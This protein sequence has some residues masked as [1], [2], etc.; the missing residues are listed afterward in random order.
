[1]KSNVNFSNTFERLYSQKKKKAP[2]HIIEK[3]EKAIST[4]IE[5]DNPESCGVKKN[6][7]LKGYYSVD[8]TKGHRILYSVS[9]NDSEF[10]IYF[11]RI[12]DHKNVYDKD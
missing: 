1:M 3:A 11:E 5:S 10:T 9:R 2:P 4:L 6:G 8:L 12:C 7:R